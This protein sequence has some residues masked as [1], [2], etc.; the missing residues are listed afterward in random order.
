VARL[1]DEVLGAGV[2]ARETGEDGRVEMKLNL[3]AVD[4]RCPFLV[5]CWKETLRLVNVQ[6]SVRRVLEDTVVTGGDGRRYLFTKGADVFMPH[7]VAHR[8]DPVWGSSEADTKEMMSFKPDNFMRAAV[9]TGDDAKLRAG[10]EKARRAAWIPFGD[11]ANLCPGRRMAMVQ[12]LAF[13]AAMVCGYEMEGINGGG[14]LSRPEMMPMAL[15]HGVVRPVESS[16]SMG[17]RI[18]R[19]TGWETVDWRFHMGKPLTEEV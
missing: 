14:V 8:F 17:L 6:A 12:H 9:V 1:R 19:R 11:G 10:D 16:E 2:F 15:G 3:A 13:M 5:A 18:R 7:A 4:E